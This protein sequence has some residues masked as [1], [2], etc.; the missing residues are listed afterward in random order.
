MQSLNF[1]VRAHAACAQRTSLVYEKRGAATPSSSETQATEGVLE[2]QKK[3]DALEAAR[4]AKTA[5]QERSVCFGIDRHLASDTRALTIF[6][7]RALSHC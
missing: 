3:D 1:L 6:G 2:A 4:I 7:A 5:K